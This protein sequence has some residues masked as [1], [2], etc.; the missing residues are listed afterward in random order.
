M[1]VLHWKRAEES[2]VHQAEDGDV[3]ANAKGERED[4][5][6]REAAIFAQHAD[7]KAD[8]LN[9][10]FEQMARAYFS[11]RFLWSRLRNRLVRRARTITLS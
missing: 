8:I 2:C 10:S 11:S 4:S 6:C 7:A 9:E 3:G 1:G 5:D